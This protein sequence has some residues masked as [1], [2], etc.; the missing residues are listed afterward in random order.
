MD[1]RNRKLVSPNF[2]K[3]RGTGVNATRVISPTSKERERVPSVMGGSDRGCYSSESAS[4]ENC[5]DCTEN[6]SRN[7]YGGYSHST[8]SQTDQIML[9]S[10]I[11]VD[12]TNTPT[13][14]FQSENR[15]DSQLVH[16][17]N[18]YPHT[19][20]DKTY[21]GNNNFQVDTCTN[22]TQ[23]HG[24]NQNQN[25]YQQHFSTYTGNAQYMK[26]RNGSQH[27]LH[28]QNGPVGAHVQ[29]THSHFENR[30]GSNIYRDGRNDPYVVNRFSGNVAET[31]QQSHTY[32]GRNWTQNNG[33]DLVPSN[34]HGIE[35]RR[36]NSEMIPSR[37]NRMNNEPRPVLPV[38]NGRHTWDSFIIPFQLIADRFDWG[39]RRQVEE[40]ILCFRDVALTFT[41]QLPAYLREDL[42][43]L[44]KEMDKRFGDHTLPETYRRNLMT[45][46]QSNSESYQK[47]A[48]RVSECVRKAFPGIN[49]VLFNELCVEHLL[50]GIP[51]QGV[52]YDVITKRPKT[53][54][55]AINLLTWHESCKRGFYRRDTYLQYQ[56][57]SYSDCD[58]KYTQNV[59]IRRVNHKRFV[60]EERLQQFGRELRDDITKNVTKSVTENIVKTIRQVVREEV[61]SV[62]NYGTQGGTSTKTV[63]CYSCHT[64]GHI[65]SNCPLKENRNTKENRSTEGCSKLKRSVD[66]TSSGK[67]GLNIRTNA[68][69]KSICRLDFTDNEYVDN[70]ICDGAEVADKTEN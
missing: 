4:V 70:F 66:M 36:S 16:G 32:D 55:E 42:D 7:D 65:S 39:K 13:H 8:L 64:E 68:S 69:P 25:T 21:L 45:M 38:F 31:A 28:G 20:S 29:N 34:E 47:Y 57:D 51:D 56:D 63:T 48:A 24:T 49:Y 52:A 10:Q 23:F 43:S 50:N 46:R 58:D 53:I 6:E 14:E 61:K 5:N 30:N 12:V 18:N 67:N 17:G 3:W 2:P 40:M 60:T 1:L 22:N 19:D 37:Y 27:G 59:D 15:N 26:D 62:Q 33:M 44:C 35:V 54:D 41:A 9:D 11:N